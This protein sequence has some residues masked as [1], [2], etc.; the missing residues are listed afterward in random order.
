MLTPSKWQL[1]E[2]E[3]DAYIAALTAHLPTLRAQAEI[4]QEELATLMG[5]SRQTYSAIERRVRPM[6]W[7][8]Y[9]S[10]VLFFDHNKKTHRL[11][12]L[13]DIF[14]Q[15]LITRFNDGVDYSSFELSAL[16]GENATQ[17]LDRLDPQALQA[18][19]SMV[20][21]EYARCTQL[22]GDV[23]IQSFGGI[24]YPAAAQRSQ[25]VEAARALKAL[26]AGGG[27]S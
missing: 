17:I 4:S 12:R 26:K 20:M 16:L 1:N 25:D 5:V 7:G 6:S 18:I 13:L 8:T 9:L 14:P 24:A 22:P 10:L 23:I 11:I 27:E 2:A 15:D 19:R 3:K 21:M